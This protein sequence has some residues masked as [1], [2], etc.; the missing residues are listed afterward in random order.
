VASAGTSAVLNVLS[1]LTG[2]GFS[3]YVAAKAAEWSMTNALRLELAQQGMLVSALHV[4]YMDTDMVCE[5][6][7]P[8]SDPMSWRSVPLT[9]SRPTRWR[10]WPTS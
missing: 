1:W 5:L 8:K 4:G 7:A 2:P 6:D 10:F 3:A 9:E